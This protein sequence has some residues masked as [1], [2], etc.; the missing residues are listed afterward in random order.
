MYPYFAQMIMMRTDIA[1]IEVHAKA[2][3]IKEVRAVIYADTDMNS[4]WKV[5]DE[6]IEPKTITVNNEEF[7]A[8]CFHIEKPSLKY[9]YCIEWSF[10]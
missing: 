10:V 2:D 6:A 7:K 4:R 3:I 9:S 1:D 5:S 8:Y